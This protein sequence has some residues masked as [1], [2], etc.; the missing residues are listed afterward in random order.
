[1]PRRE[2]AHHMFDGMRL[3]RGKNSEA[4]TAWSGADRISGLPEGVL[5]HVLSLLPAHDAVRTCVLARRWR[6]LWRSAP[7]IRITGVKGWRDADRFVAFV[8]RLLSLRRGHAAP[9]ESCRMKFAAGD[10]DFDYF[11]LA[12]KQHVSHWIKEA[13]RLDVRVLQLSF[14]ELES[15]CL[16]DL[17]LVCQHL[18]RLELSCV[19]ANDSILDFSG[20]PALVALRMKYCFI[21][22]D[23]L[24]SASLKQLRMIDCEFPRNRTRISLPSLISLELTRCHGWTPL[25]ECTP[26]LETA[27]VSLA[28]DSEDYCANNGTICGD[29]SCESCQYHYG[30]DDNRNNCVFL[31]GLSEATHVELSAYHGV[32]VFNRDLKWC[33]TFTKLKTLLLHEWCVAADN[34]ALICFLQHSPALEKLTL[35]LYMPSQYLLETNGRY[36]PLELPFASHHLKIV[37]IKCEEV[38]WRVHKILS[39]LSTYGIPLNHIRIQQTNRSSGSGYVNLV[40]T[41]LS[42]N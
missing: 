31:K 2:D 35:R 6:H 23:K 14:A 30:F 10:F 13:V 7:G 36:N 29:G 4:S 34:N 9:V 42:F 28:R 11:L 8:D 3:K 5:H 32:F 24:F 19:D 12:E 33:P 1:M 15:F 21:N 38:N 26:S 17:H 39:S 20:C 22:A 41:G 27:I 25:L 40:C 16:P 18:V 37:E